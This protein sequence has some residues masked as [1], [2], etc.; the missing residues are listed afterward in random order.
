MTDKDEMAHVFDGEIHPKVKVMHDQGFG[1]CCTC[2]H[3]LP[4]E[5]LESLSDGVYHICEHCKDWQNRRK[6]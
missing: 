3:K 5:K 1:I 4:L 2:G 6:F